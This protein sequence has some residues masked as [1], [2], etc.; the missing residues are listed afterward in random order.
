MK[1]GFF[2]FFLNLGLGG[3]GAVLSGRRDFEFFKK[4]KV[5]QRERER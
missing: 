4:R 5:K 2:Y 1:R 3:K